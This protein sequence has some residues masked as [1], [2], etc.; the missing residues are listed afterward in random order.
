MASGGYVVK[1]H[2]CHG[3]KPGL[4]F[5]D[6]LVYLNKK[7]DHCCEKDGMCSKPTRMC[8]EHFVSGGPCMKPKVS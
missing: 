7:V 5:S 4:F 3:E 1:C 2:N 6:L 8:G